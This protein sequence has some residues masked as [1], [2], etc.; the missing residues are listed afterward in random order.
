MVPK[1][2]ALFNGI[3]ASLSVGGGVT[4]KDVI[5]FRRLK[6]IADFGTT[7][8][9][10]FQGLTESSTTPESNHASTCFSKALQI[11]GDFG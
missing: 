3:S 6:F 10:K 7:T 8:T 9:G 1:I 4:S 2:V 5:K 11:S